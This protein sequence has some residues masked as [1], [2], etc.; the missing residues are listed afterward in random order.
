MSEIL[1]V[2]HELRWVHVWIALFAVAAGFM[3]WKMPVRF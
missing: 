2:L 3:V 1:A